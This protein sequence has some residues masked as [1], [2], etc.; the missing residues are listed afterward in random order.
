MAEG[1]IITCRILPIIGSFS[2]YLGR[3]VLT[4]IDLF[5]VLEFTK[6][7]LVFSQPNPSPSESKPKVSGD[8]TVKFL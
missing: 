3:V 6:L 4:T 7:T 5:V 8:N 2:N 1:Y